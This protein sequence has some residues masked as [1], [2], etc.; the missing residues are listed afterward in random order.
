MS[1]DCRF[2]IKYIYCAL[3][4]QYEAM[5]DCDNCADENEIPEGTGKAKGE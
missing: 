2:A 5:E 3:H 4:D 1:E